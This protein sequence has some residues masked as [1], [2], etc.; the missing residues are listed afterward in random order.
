MH[1]G[2]QDLAGEDAALRVALLIMLM[3]FSVRC[4]TTAA[5]SPCEWRCFVSDTE[6]ALPFDIH[7]VLA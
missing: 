2:G 4:C 1:V 5:A 3:V 6:C 7:T